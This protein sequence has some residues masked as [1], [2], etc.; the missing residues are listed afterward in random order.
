MIYEITLDGK[1]YGI[2]IDDSTVDCID[3]K[4]D[5]T[6][7]KAQVEQTQNIEDIDDLPD[8]D[9]EDEEEKD[10]IYTPLQGRVIAIYAHPGQFVKKDEVLAILESMKMEIQILATSDCHIQKVCIHEGDI[11]KANSEAFLIESK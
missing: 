4:E 10:V 5:I 9:F 7:N 6:M 11:L 8:F 3:I 1:H 2:E